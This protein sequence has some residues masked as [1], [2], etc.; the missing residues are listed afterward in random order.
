MFINKG[1]EN[2]EHKTQRTI[3]NNEETCPD[4]A[5]THTQI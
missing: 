4:T 5:T 3:N 2:T 1:K